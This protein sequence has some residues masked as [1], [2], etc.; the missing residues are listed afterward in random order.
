MTPEQNYRL[1]E[2]IEANRRFILMA[3]LQNP[4][5]LERAEERIRQIFD[6]PD[7]GEQ[8][9]HIPGRIVPMEKLP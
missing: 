7:H 2:E 8:P 3:Y 9:P 4:E 6:V 1:L 5:L